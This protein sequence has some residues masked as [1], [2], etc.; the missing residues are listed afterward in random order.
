MSICV[1]KYLCC[2]II[3]NQRGKSNRNVFIWQPFTDVNDLPLGRMALQIQKDVSMIYKKCKGR[4]VSFV[5]ILDVDDV[6]L[7]ERKYWLNSNHL[8]MKGEKSTAAPGFNLTTSIC[9]PIATYKWNNPDEIKY[10][11]IYPSRDGITTKY[12]Q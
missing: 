9:K 10:S 5:L 4:S 3:R 6:L 1:N 12:N 8:R 11:C 2:K 7:T